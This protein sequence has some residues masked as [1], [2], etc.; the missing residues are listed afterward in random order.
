MNLPFLR[1]A[2]CIAVAVSLTSSCSTMHDFARDYGTAAGCIGGAALGGGITYLVTHDAKKALVG[3]LAGGM[4]GCV[5]GNV[6]QNREQ[7]LAKV[8]QEEQIRI[9][10]Q[11]LNAQEKSQ[12]GAGGHCRSG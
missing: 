12:G 9:S 5:V 10:T 7:A 1:K 11:A 6:W 2:A 4:A 8:A 3:G